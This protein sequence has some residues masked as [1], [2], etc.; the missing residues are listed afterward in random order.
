[1]KK[2]FVI[3]LLILLCFSANYSHVGSPGV[4]M[5]GKA[6]PYSVLVSVNPPDVIPGEADVSIYVTGDGISKVTAKPVY[7]YTGDE[8]TPRADEMYATSESPNQYQGIVWLMESGTASL[9]IYVEGDLGSGETIVP[10]MAAA[11][12]QNEMAPGL[13]YTLAG[14]GTLLTILMITIIGAAVSDGL[15]K[16]GEEVPKKA[17]GKKLKGIIVATL[18]VGLVL[19]GGK[20]WWDAEASSY[21]RFMYKAPE[22]N[23]WVDKENG[24]SLLTLQVDS[25]KL[26]KNRLSM[27]YVVPDHGKIM[28]MFIIREDG[29]D[30]FA[31]L[32][33]KRVDSLT[34]KVQ[35]PPVPKGRYLV[36]GDIVRLNGYT[37]TISDTLE[38]DAVP[39]PKS[40]LDSA[41]VKTEF[42]DPDNTYIVS[43][44]FDSEKEPEFPAPLGDIVVCGKPGIAT[45]LP[46]GSTAVWEHK[47]G[48]PFIAGKVY[49]LTFAI[50]DPEGKPAELQ[51]YMGMMG[52]A[53]V[54][55]KEGGVYVHLHP[56][57]NYSMASK[58]IIENRISEN[59]AQPAIPDR[60]AFRDSVDRE[61]LKVAEMDEG[62][63]NEYLMR[64]MEH[65]GLGEH[66]EHGATVSFPYAFPQPGN[67]RIWIQMK[68]NG[69]VLNSSFD[70]EVT[71]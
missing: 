9:S 66:A 12:A 70:A 11:T 13:G 65:L 3:S 40:D 16:P 64:D 31:H 7:W 58:D 5:E 34:F 6:G 15:V 54:Y 28:H 57:G 67:Y 29:L 33:P 71:L 45:P 27:N 55:R 60:H 37:E 25:A 46:D 17:K 52:H 39:V 20:S 43:N 51:P 61:I 4:V 53:V 22:A 2:I 24:N 19:F 59:S 10:V 14:L 35:L 48:E 56:V 30:V 41:M 26:S 68:R 62:M 21:Q 49:P 36:F 32:H 69:K 18:V 63:R 50:N 23:S 47:A 1:M 44:A 8:G 42:D 38:I